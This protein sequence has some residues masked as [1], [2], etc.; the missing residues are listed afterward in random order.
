MAA[1]KNPARMYVFLMVPPLCRSC[2]PRLHLTVCQGIARATD[3]EKPRA[4]RKR[5][6]SRLTSLR[7][8]L[9]GAASEEAKDNS[10]GS[11]IIV[12]MSIGA[13]RSPVIVEIDHADF[14]MAGCTVINAAACLIRNTVLRSGVAASSGD[15]EVGARAADEG[16][17][18]WGD[19]QAM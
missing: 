2:L 8:L 1:N 11:P 15:G 5:P 10:G 7:A 14:P 19:S 4:L 6:C 17:R 18:E 13:E 9:V 16:F 12:L 3:F